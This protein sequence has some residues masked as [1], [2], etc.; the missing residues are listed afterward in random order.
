MR[1]RVL[2]VASLLALS[3]CSDDGSGDE[4][5]KTSASETSP[6]ATADRLPIG[7]DDLSLEASDYLSP[8]GFEPE[9]EIDLTSDGAA[10]WTS[11]HR[12]TDAFDLGQPVPGADALL[13]AVAFLVPPEASSEDALSAVRQ[14]AVDAGAKVSDA[15]GGF[16]SLATEGIEVRD[17][18]GQVVASRDGGIALDAVPGGRLQI[19]AADH[20]ED[21]LLIVAFTPDAKLAADADELVQQLAAAVTLA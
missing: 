13:V 8:E 20:G 17:G 6:A 10:G 18:E 5:S 21:P 7:K 2:L 14:S 9:L 19:W 11:V 12:G 16:G 15:A 1:T 4:P 3:A